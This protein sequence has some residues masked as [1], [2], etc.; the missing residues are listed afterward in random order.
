MKKDTQESKKELT[1]K[2]MGVAIND[3]NEFLKKVTALNTDSIQEHNAPSVLALQQE[4]DLMLED[5]F[6]HGTSKCYEMKGKLRLQDI[7]VLRMNNRINIFELHDT[8][9]KNVEKIVAHLT[10]IRDNFSKKLGHSNTDSTA[11]V[12]KAYQGLN[13]HS[14]IAKAASQLYLDGYYS[15]AIEDATKALMQYVQQKSGSN[16]DGVSLMEHVFSQKNPVLKFN[17]LADESDRNEQKG[18]MQL[19]CGAMTG[20][21]NPRA[22]KIIEDDPE[23]AL[24]Y[25]AFI[26]M[27]AKLVDKST[28]CI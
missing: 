24:E 4:L 3:I 14:H 22:H 5:I 13:L 8:L 18:F 20:L 16:S 11:L 23:T 17:A 21:R 19:F 28:K 6:G 15:N 26:S 12:I 10:P 25:I 27:L 2:E 1:P 7:L 9:R